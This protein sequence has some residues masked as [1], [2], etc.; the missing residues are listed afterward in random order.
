MGSAAI[1]GIEDDSGARGRT[2]DGGGGLEGLVS[3]R[4]RSIQ[5]STRYIVLDG[6]KEWAQVGNGNRRHVADE[7]VDYI[8][9]TL[10]NL[11]GSV[12]ASVTDAENRNMKTQEQLLE[13]R[14][15]NHYQMAM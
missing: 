6:S 1:V 8:N 4:Q 7:M 3:K 15:I 12:V 13:H 10:T 9:I 14:Q 5:M 2:Q 11:L